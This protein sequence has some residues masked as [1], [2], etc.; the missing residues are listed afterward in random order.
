MSTKHDKSKAKFCVGN[1]VIKLGGDSKDIRRVIRVDTDRYV[2][3]K[4]IVAFDWDFLYRL[5]KKEEI[6]EYKARQI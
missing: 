4:S 1:Y 3:D 6:L 2:F 5:A